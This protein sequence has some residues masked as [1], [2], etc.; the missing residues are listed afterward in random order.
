MSGVDVEEIFRRCDSGGLV[1]LRAILSENG[2]H[3]LA[4]CFRLGLPDRRVRLLHFFIWL[5]D[6]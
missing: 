6:G 2:D 5:V 1:V 4:T 3:L